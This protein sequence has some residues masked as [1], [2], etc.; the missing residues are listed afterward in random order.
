MLHIFGFALFMING[1]SPHN[2]DEISFLVEETGV[3]GGNHRPFE[4]RMSTSMGHSENGEKDPIYPQNGIQKMGEMPT[5][6]SQ[7]VR[8][9]INH[10]LGIYSNVR[11]GSRN[12][13]KGGGFWA[14]ILRRGGGV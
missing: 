11:F 2:D 9:I 6:I 10:I 3:P 8:Q 5:Y 13:L 4:D 14:R 7:N 12:S 1:L